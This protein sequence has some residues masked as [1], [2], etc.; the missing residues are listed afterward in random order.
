MKFNNREQKNEEELNGARNIIGKR[1]TLQ[2]D[3]ETLGNIRLEGKMIGNIKT[4]LKLIVGHSSEVEGSVIAQNVDV[5]GQITGNIEVSEVLTL[6]ST[7]VING[8]IMTNKLVVETGA[9]FNGG[10][11]MGVS[12]KEIKIARNLT[13]E[14]VVLQAQS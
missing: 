5:E 4:K 10:C 1:T 13:E 12:K 11:K 8:D 6:K 7:A 14:P 9:V 3:L 2:G